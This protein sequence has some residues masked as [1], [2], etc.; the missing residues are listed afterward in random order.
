MVRQGPIPLFLHGILEY[1][2]A[3]ILFAAPFVF[4]F[5]DLGEPTAAAIVAGVIVLMSA[6]TTKGFRTSLVKSVPLQA[7][8][9]LDYLLAAAF[10]AAPFVLGFSDEGSP[11]AF[12]IVA[13]VVVLLLAIAT[14][15]RP[16]RADAAAAGRH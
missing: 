7:H 5:S 14:R 10:I 6:A 1:L 2:G 11:T 8:A 12:F 9:A 3:A 15:W 16:K 4:A 13:G